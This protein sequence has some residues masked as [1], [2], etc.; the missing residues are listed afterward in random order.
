M[1][2]GRKGRLRSPFCMAR[3]SEDDCRAEFHGNK[4]DD[5]KVAWPAGID[6]NTQRFCLVDIL[7]VA[8]AECH[9]ARSENHNEKG[10]GND[11]AVHGEISKVLQVILVRLTALASRVGSIRD[12]PQLFFPAERTMHHSSPIRVIRGSNPST[13]HLHLLTEYRFSRR[14]KGR[15]SSR[16]SRYFRISE[17]ENEF[18]CR[19]ED[20]NLHTLAST[21]T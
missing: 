2:C 9:H 16:P 11:G 8:G 21:W 12:I 18:W 20:S 14:N 1:A 5:P 17:I 10:A 13:G 6:G 19:K 15:E 3:P 4:K 7:L